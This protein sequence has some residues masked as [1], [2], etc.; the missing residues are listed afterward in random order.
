MTSACPACGASA[1]VGDAAGGTCGRCGYATGEAN[2]CPHCGSVARTLGQGQAAVCAV[3][4]GPRIPHNHGGAAAATALKQQKLHLVAARVA[5]ITT[6]VQSIFA[7][8]ATLIGLGF[9]PGSLLAKVLVF[10]IALIPLV[11]ALRSRSRAL[12]ARAKAT[13]AGERAW[14]AAAEALA[15]GSARGVTATAVAKTLGLDETQAD[16]LLTSL[17]VHDRTRVDVGDDAEVVYSVAPDRHL[18]PDERDPLDELD[19]PET[20]KDAR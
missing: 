6:V 12:A 10:G 5:S 4:G 20:K 15:A 13:E 9:A 8:I 11:L 14:Q 1:F 16:R 19:V 18:E 7:A 2:R 3:C 17:A